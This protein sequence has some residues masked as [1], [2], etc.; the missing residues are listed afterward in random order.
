[1]AAT[2]VLEGAGRFSAAG[3]PLRTKTANFHVIEILM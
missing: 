1:V 2:A 3:A